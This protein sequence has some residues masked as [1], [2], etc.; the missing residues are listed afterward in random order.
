MDLFVEYKC[1]Q[2]IQTQ[3]CISIKYKYI[4]HV[5]DKK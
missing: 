4:K 5:V 1:E 2:H 3:A